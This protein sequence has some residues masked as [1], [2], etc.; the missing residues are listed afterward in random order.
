AGTIDQLTRSANWRLNLPL[1]ETQDTR[2]N[3]YWLD[4]DDRAGGRFARTERRVSVA[5]RS[6]FRWGEL[7]V[8][9][10]P[11]VAYRTSEGFL[12]QH[13]LHP[14]LSLAVAGPLHEL[15]IALGYR[16]L[17]RPGLRAPDLDEYHLSMDWRY[18]V[19]RHQLGIEYEHLLAQPDG[20]ENLDL[21]RAGLFWRY[22]F[23]GGAP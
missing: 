12:E 9:A 3:L 14:T 7:D 5:H 22:K 11:G 1:A 4:L 20:G 19:E 18:Q 15:G 16:T 10:A 21:W 8:T 17:E 2:L 23:F 6:R 13:S